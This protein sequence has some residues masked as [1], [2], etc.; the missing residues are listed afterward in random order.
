M[1]Q[2]VPDVYLIEGLRITQVYALISDE[3]LT[4]I[5]AGFPGEADRIAAQ[6]AEGGYVLSDVQ[7]IVVTH[8]HGDHTGSL[9]EL[10]R[11]SG[12]RVLAHQDEVPYVEQT[13]TMPTGSFAQRLAGWLGAVGMFRAEPCRVDQPLQDG[14]E[15]DALGGLCVIHVPGHTPGNVALYQPE[16]R[17]LFCGDTLFNGSPFTGRGGLGLPPR[18]FSVNASQAAESARKLADLPLDV[19]CPGHGEPILEDAQV[20]IQEVVGTQAR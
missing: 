15:I 5:D 1:R 9:A 6:L 12:A 16:R 2:I 7:G 10:A 20:M 8:G 18:L 4:L 3:G 11:R 14:D 19:L 13:A 17:L